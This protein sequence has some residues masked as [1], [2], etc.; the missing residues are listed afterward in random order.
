[1]P[2]GVTEIQKGTEIVVFSFVLG[3]DRSFDRD[4]SFDER[5]EIVAVD[6]R[7]RIEELGVANYSMLNR[8]SE[9]FVP[10]PIRQRA[11]RVGIGDDQ[12]GMMKRADQILTRAGIDAGLPADA[13]IDLREKSRRDGNVRDAAEIDRRDKAGQMDERSAA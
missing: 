9:S 12:R 2:D 7:Q 8:L 13:A 6:R 5:F 3:H 10:D 1:M 11:Q 4:V